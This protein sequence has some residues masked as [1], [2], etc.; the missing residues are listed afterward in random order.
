MARFCHGKFSDE[1]TGKLR[2]AFLNGD[3]LELL[4]QP[5]AM[6]GSDV[7]PENK[8][9]QWIPRTHAA[10]ARYRSGKSDGYKRS[11]RK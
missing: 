11:P 3:Q 2:A 9:G 6:C 8:S 5:C 10:P 7:V 4:S 1:T